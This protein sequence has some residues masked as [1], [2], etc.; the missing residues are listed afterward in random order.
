MKY[1]INI[2]FLFCSLSFVSCSKDD[3]IITAEPVVETP[4]AEEQ[5]FV[6][7]VGSMFAYAP[8]SSGVVLSDGFI[9]T[10]NDSGNPS[11]FYK[12]NPENGA[13]VQSI[14]V[15]NFDNKDWE[16]ITADED[17][18][19]IGDF[20]NNDGIRTDLRVLKIDKSQFANNTA[21]SVSVTAE[22]I[23]FSYTE[24]TS[25]LSTSTHNFDCETI[26]SK[27]DFLYLFTKDRGDNNTRA[28]KLSK[29]PGQYP[30]TTLASYQVNGLITG[31][32]YNAQTNELVLIGYSASGH[33]NSFIYLFS[34]FTDDSFFAG[35][36]AKKEIGNSTNDWQTEGIA[37]G[38]TNGLDLFISCE[39][40]NFSKSKLYKTTKAK[41]GF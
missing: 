5:V 23:Q 37:F 36:V 8:E 1:I 32:D 35:N 17:Y 29:V 12:V 7:E 30:L 10:F 39:T 20:G 25:F 31:G 2:F 14:S 4:I 38:S 33:R 27:G 16:D 15:T 13:L 6:T 40:T 26:I 34:N 9:Y 41:L 19:Y 18:I 28:Y 3:E 24:Q 11:V 22:I 21:A